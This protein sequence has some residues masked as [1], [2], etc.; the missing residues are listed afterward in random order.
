VRAAALA[1]LLVLGGCSVSVPPERRW[2]SPDVP[3]TADWW[4][5]CRGATALPGQTREIDR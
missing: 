4:K 2:C 1:V 5:I 3:R